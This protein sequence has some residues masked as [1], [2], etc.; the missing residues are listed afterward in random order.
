MV[1]WLIETYLFK[2]VPQ[3]LLAL[4]I[5][6]LKRVKGVIFM[7]NISISAQNTYYKAFDSSYS[8]LS[9]GFASNSLTVVN[10]VPTVRILFCWC[11][12][13]GGN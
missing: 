12:Q 2:V 6:E 1:L 3:P 5:F 10:G 4:E 8:R 7:A 9:C 13:S 11:R